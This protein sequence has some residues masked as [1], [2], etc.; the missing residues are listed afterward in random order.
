MAAE[1]SK[2]GSPRCRNAAQ[3]FVIPKHS[4]SKL[5]SL[6]LSLSQL[7]STSNTHTHTQQSRHLGPS[8]CLTPG[9]QKTALRIMLSDPECPGRVRGFTELSLNP[10][11]ARENRSATRG[12]NKDNKH[13]AFRQNKKKK[14][15]GS[16]REVLSRC[17]GP[18]KRQSR[19]LKS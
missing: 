5:C 14:K 8:Y 7:H 1:E 3:I 16:G 13:G 12:I 6:S 9:G 17:A 11:T 18:E 2:T 10:T 4:Q 15:L 19:G